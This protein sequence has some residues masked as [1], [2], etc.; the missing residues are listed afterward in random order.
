MKK[1]IAMIVCMLICLSLLFGCTGNRDTNAS[2]IPTDENI[3]Y[4]L[5]DPDM[6]DSIVVAPK[7]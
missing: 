1:R 3:V 4:A 2:E 6:A 7:E 5:K